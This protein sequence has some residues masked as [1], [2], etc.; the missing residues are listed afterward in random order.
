MT[1]KQALTLKTGTQVRERLPLLGR[2]ATQVGAVVLAKDGF[3]VVRWYDPRAANKTFNCNR[4]ASIE[5]LSIP[6]SP[7]PNAKGAKSP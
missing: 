7:R 2:R 6:R 5:L 1:V 3:V 4:S